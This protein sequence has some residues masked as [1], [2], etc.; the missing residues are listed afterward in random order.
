MKLVI[1]DSY[2]LTEGDLDWSGL[3]ALVDEVEA[4]PRT[5]YAEAA[6][7][8]GDA[9]FVVVN[10]TFIDDAV[11]DACPKI[12]WIGLTATGTDSLDIA[13]CRRHGVHLAV[14]IM[15]IGMSCLLNPYL[16]HFPIVCPD[17][18]L[19]L[20]SYL[21]GIFTVTSGINHP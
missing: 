16:L 13:A 12:R 7:R 3:T 18:D 1:L 14:K 9:E 8:I 10:K 2:A 20:R 19:M 5:P 17:I 21:L 11:L 15:V 6:A 4:W